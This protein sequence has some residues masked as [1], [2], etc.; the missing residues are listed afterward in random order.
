[1]EAV[2]VSFSFMHPDVGPT[3]FWG[4]GIGEHEESGT[5]LL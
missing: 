2:E 1:M 3:I 4:R 5:L